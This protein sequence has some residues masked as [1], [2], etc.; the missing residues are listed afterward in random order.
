[1]HWRQPAAKRDL[2]AAI[3]R[4]IARQELLDVLSQDREV[5]RVK[6][7]IEA[8]LRGKL[9]H[10]AAAGLKE[11]LDLTRPA[12]VAESWSGGKQMLE[13][14]LVVGQ[15]MHIPGAAHPS[16]FDRADDHVAHCVSGNSL[17]PG[18]YPVGVAFPAPNWHSRPA[19]PSFTSSIFPRRGGRSPIPI[20]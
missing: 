8:H 15:P 12:L 7:A 20:T 9:D 3:R 16:H 4:R 14:H 13:Q 10:E 17:T 19:R 2:H 1:M 18:D 11:L 5:P 6:A